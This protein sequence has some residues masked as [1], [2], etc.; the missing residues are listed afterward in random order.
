ML[1]EKVECAAVSP[2][3]RIL[4]YI[5]VQYFPLLLQLFFDFGDFN[6]RICQVVEMSVAE[7]NDDMGLLTQQLASAPTFAWLEPKRCQ[8]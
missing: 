8:P 7:N 4:S 2:H 1:G 3:L 6:D 5:Q